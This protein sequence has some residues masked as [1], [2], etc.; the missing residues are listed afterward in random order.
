MRSQLSRVA[1]LRPPAAAERNE[2]HADDGQ[3]NSDRRIK[4]PARMALDPRLQLLVARRVHQRPDV[5]DLRVDKLAGADRL[6]TIIDQE[7]EG[8]S[9]EQQAERPYQE[10]DHDG[11]ISGGSLSGDLL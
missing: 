5:T 3:Y 4:N 11:F 9:E 10:A 8:R 2:Q 1:D 7:N 6:G